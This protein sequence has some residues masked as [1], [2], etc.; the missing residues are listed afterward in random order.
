MY[1]SIT[2]LKWDYDVDTIKGGAYRVVL[3][4]RFAL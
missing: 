1:T 3:P 4:W 2:N